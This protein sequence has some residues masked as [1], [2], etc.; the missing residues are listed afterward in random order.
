MMAVGAPPFVLALKTDNYYGEI[1]NGC[2]DK[3][4]G[5]HEQLYKRRFPY[6]N[7][8]VDYDLKSLITV[9]LSPVG[10]RVNSFADIVSHPWMQYE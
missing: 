10:M 8:P 6:A 7:F 5:K 9:L 3:F 4:W 1:I 2:P